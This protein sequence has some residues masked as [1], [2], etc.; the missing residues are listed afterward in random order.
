[1]CTNRVNNLLALAM[2]VVVSPLAGGANEVS[3]IPGQAC[4]TTWSIDPVGPHDV[5]VVDF[6]G[7]VRFYINRC[8]AEEALGGEPVLEVDHDKRTVELR[9]QPPPNRDCDTFWTPVCGLNGTFGPLEIGLWHFFCTAAE[10]TFSI[11][12]SVGGAGAEPTS[13]LYVDANAPGANNG[14][15]WRDAYFHLQDALA[16]A[17]R[18]TEIRVARGT[19]WPD[20]GEGVG[21]GD[22]NAT[23][24][25]KTGVTLK[26]GYAGWRGA[27]PN[28]RKI[29]VY[30]TVLS[31]D[32]FEDDRP[33][34]RMPDM[35]DN[36]HRFDNSLHVVTISG[37]DAT[38]VLDGFTISGGMAEDTDEPD[39][40]GSGGG[41]Y[42]DGGSATIRNCLITDNVAAY[43]GA[44]VYCRS[45]GTVTL[46]GCTVT[47]NW[48][49]W[50]G[51][52]VYCHATSGLAVDQCLIVGN[53][54]LYQGGGACNFGNGKLVLSNTVLS[55]NRAAEPDWG[56]GGGLYGSLTKT[57]VY[58]CTF[59][60]NRAASGSAIS[61]GL[62]GSARDTELHLYNCILWG[63][64]D[65]IGDDD[66]S[67]IDITYSDVLGGWT[68]PGNIDADP[69]FAQ[70]GHWDSRGTMGDNGD[71][72]WEQ[73]NYR[74][75]WN[76]PCV[77][78]GNLDVVPDARGVDLGGQPRVSGATV[79]MGAYELRNDP[80]IAN[81]GPDAM[82][83]TLDGVK[84]SVTFDGSQSYDPEGLPLS[85]QWYYKGELVPDANQ[86]VLT[87]ELPVGDSVLTLV[88]IDPTGIAASDDVVAQVT[89]VIGVMSFVSPQKLARSHPQD[90]VT[91]TILPKD[92]TPS[93]FDHGEPMLLF[94]GGVR[95]YKQT[96][97][98][99]LSG[100]TL[101]MATFK[102]QAVMAALP[103]DGPVELRVIG[104]FREG[105][106]FSGTD[107]VTIE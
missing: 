73:G 21:L 88:V 10:A 45:P 98:V 16:A 64:G 6:S 41:I 19:Y 43:Y 50:A 87:M 1:M 100:D 103:E 29:Y 12:F 90:V 105:R 47:N 66:A 8:V 67:V 106:Y 93:D 107:T 38:A 95:A 62:Y 61:T 18:G 84:G 89:P 4:P 20:E 65:L 52:G 7:P 102:G 40:L 97:F 86:A 74:V 72:I 49:N 15:R 37:T 76:S 51:G 75:R 58:N 79:D 5:D 69:C 81:A 57:F 96:A 56:R 48:A 46:I 63:E 35:I 78:A 3:W 54:A 30:E 2:V 39:L 13:I 53:G 94:P 92:R 14:S 80:P 9:F 25:L 101:V 11:E 82:G 24:Q 42:S 99:W 31:G 34:A 33:S 77:D 70:A 83:F 22:E 60:G 32:L 85:Y 68:G 23:F 17:T 91:L 44:G 27:N 104:R 59:A 28:E 26:G 55:G 36:W 71:D